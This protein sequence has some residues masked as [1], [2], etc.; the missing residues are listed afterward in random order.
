M[1]Y[2]KTHP[3][4]IFET[5]DHVRD[6]RGVLPDRG[7]QAAPV[8]FDKAACTVG[9]V[10]APG[11]FIPGYPYGMTFGFTVGSRTAPTGG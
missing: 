8:M 5:G 2:S 3:T 10:R 11:L 9:A 4:E 6:L 1:L 7:G